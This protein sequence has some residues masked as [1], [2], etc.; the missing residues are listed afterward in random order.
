MEKNLKHIIEGAII[1]AIVT[2]LF[3]T[4]KDRFDFTNINNIQYLKETIISYGNIASLIFILLMAIAIII[5]PIPSL[6]LDAAAGIIWGPYLATLYAVIGAEIGAIIAFLIARKLGKAGIKKIFKKDITFCKDCSDKWLFAIVLISRLFPFF[7]FD[8]I[9][10][11]AG[12]TNMKLRNFAIATF[13]GMIPMTFIFA[14]FGQVLFIGSTLAIFF[15][16][17]L[18]ISMFAI[19]YIIKKYNLFNLKGKI[20]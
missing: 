6:P 14:Y 5:S 19:P 11:G 18:I 3:Y 9:S 4:L 16:I 10:Y 1:V 8:I 20:N 7:Q 12:L 15:T 17:I 2:I 13:F